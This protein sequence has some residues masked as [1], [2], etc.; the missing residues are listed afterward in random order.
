MG[1]KIFRK[2]IMLG[3][4]CG[5]IGMAACSGE[6][7]VVDSSMDT[8]SNSDVFISESV[9][10]SLEESTYSEE[11]S[12]F[13]ESSLEEESSSSEESSSNAESLEDGD[14]ELPEDRF[15]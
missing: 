11:S 10:N 13:E 1:K 4:V 12:F 7:N 6:E 3:L 5:A 14:I 9:E 8:P 2:I 15:D